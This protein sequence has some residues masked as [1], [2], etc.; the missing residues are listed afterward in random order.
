MHSTQKAIAGR[1]GV[2]ASLVSRA[3]R[4]QAERIG[5]HPDTIRRICAE[6]ARC[7]YAPNVAALSLRGGATRM[8]GVVVRDFTDPFFGPIVGALQRLAT[9]QDFSL[10]MT[11]GGAEGCDAPDL[12]PLNKYRLDG[13]ILVGSDFR[14]KGLAQAIQRGV[15][16]VRLGAGSDD[17]GVVQVCVDQG[18]GFSQL[19]AYLQQLGHRHIG[20]LGHVTPGNVRRETALKTAMAK[21]GIAVRPDAFVHAADTAPAAVAGALRRIR[22]GSPAVRP[23][24]L[25][26]SDDVMA[27]TLLRVLHEAGVVVPRDLSVAGVDDIPFAHLAVPALTTIRP[28]LADMAE[29][30]FQLASGRA[31]AAGGACFEI[32]PELVVRESCAPPSGK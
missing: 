23:T 8:L 16:V 24:A 31:P 32:R 12:L 30:V 3:L 4:G 7:G 22:S 14:P 15:P 29:R 25:V 20:Y 6:A 5:A 26:A 18:A 19:L 9:A 13:F 11:G 2:S 17:D 27:L 28:P 21:A 1:L 10:V